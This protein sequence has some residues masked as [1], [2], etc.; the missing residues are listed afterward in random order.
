MSS[1]RP[2]V[3]PFQAPSQQQ[4]QQ[5]QQQP[6][7]S[8]LSVASPSIRSCYDFDMFCDGQLML[9]NPKEERTK[10]ELGSLSFEQR[11][12]L[13]DE[14]GPNERGTNGNRFAVTQDENRTQMLLLQISLELE[15]QRVPN[16]HPAKYAFLLA[17]QQSRDY[18]NDEKFRIRFLRAD[19][20]DPAAACRRI[21][22]HFHVK[23]KLFGDENGI[24]GRDVTVDDL[25]PYEQSMLIDGS[26]SATSAS[27]LTSDTHHKKGHSCNGKLNGPFRFLQYPDYAGRPILFGRPAL[28]DHFN[29]KST[30]RKMFLFVLFG[31]D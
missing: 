22:A 26:T 9:I 27:A 30:V 29:V 31:W 28:M 13:Y 5:Q 21:I 1:N 2:L 17:L 11:K 16:T 3:Q 4:Q 19:R 8:L 12:Q 23:R 7:A 24:L 10:R 25:T 6:E 15:L 18:V 20:Y 14:M